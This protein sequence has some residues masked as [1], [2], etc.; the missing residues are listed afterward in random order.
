MFLLFMFFVVSNVFFFFFG[1]SGYELIVSK[2]SLFVG[3]FLE[4]VVFGSGN[5]LF[6]LGLIFY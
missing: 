3:I 1:N 4:F 5:F 2:V 6:F